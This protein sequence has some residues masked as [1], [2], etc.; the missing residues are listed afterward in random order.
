MRIQLSLLLLYG[1]SLC[2]TIKTF[3]PFYDLTFPL[4]ASENPINGYNWEPRDFSILVSFQCLKKIHSFWWKN[5][6][7][8]RMLKRSVNPDYSIVSGIASRWYSIWRCAWIVCGTR[9]FSR[10]RIFCTC[11]TNMVHKHIC[12]S[13]SMKSLM[14][15]L[16]LQLK[17]KLLL[18]GKWEIVMLEHHLAVILYSLHLRETVEA[19]FC[20]HTL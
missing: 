20:N 16:Q 5:S 4:I 15:F 19:S 9:H 11:S 1:L 8:S 7:L 17:M 13:T 18:K 10:G 3:F 12:E 6:F 14:A 2:P